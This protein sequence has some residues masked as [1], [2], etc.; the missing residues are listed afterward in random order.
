MKLLIAS[1]IKTPLM[2]INFGKITVKGATMITFLKIEKK[3][4]CYITM[5]LTIGRKLQQKC[6]ETV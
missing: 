4:A 1:A 6:K 3:M 2:P 5:W